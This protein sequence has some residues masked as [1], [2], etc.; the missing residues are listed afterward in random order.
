MS[1]CGGGAVLTG[2]YRNKFGMTGLRSVL[3]RYFGG[4][5]LVDGFV[6][7]SKMGCI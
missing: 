7:V 1:L 3:K 2:G 5:S 6:N 4:V